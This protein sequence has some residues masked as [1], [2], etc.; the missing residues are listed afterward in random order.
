MVEGDGATLTGATL[1]GVLAETLGDA[2]APWHAA[3]STAVIA[4]ARYEFL[5]TFTVR[6]LKLRLIEITVRRL[7]HARGATTR[8]AQPP[9]SLR[10]CTMPRIR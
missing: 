7:Y 2:P 1:A 4:R 5:P 3:S 10:A 6:L 9:E 8:E